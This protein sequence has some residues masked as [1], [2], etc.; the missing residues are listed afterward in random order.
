[1]ERRKKLAAWRGESRS[2]DKVGNDLGKT[3]QR[4]PQA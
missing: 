2:R 1:M 4:P 3:K